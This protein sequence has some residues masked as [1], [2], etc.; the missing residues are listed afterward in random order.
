MEYLVIARTKDTAAALM[1]QRE[2]V[3]WERMSDGSLIVRIKI[4]DEDLTPA[5]LGW[6]EGSLNFMM[7][8]GTV[9]WWTRIAPDAS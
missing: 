1:K 4:D 2:V 6:F 3:S 9:I 7:N 5:D 8:A